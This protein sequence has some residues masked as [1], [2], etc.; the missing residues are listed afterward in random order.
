MDQRATP[1]ALLTAEAVRATGVA[2]LALARRGR[3]KNWTLDESRL[4]ATAE[5]VAEVTRENYPDLRVPYHSRWRHFEIGHDRFKTAYAAFGLSGAER[6]R[7]RIELAIVSV[8]LDAGAGD[9][10][11]YATEEGTFGR[12]E[13]LAL[14]SLDLV[15]RGHFAR[16]GSA[17]WCVDAEKLE[18][19]TPTH[20]ARAF[21]VTADNPLAGLDGRAG[22]L[23]ALGARVAHRS[24]IFGQPARLGRFYDHLARRAKN[25]RIK[26]AKILES[27][28]GVF[29]P[30]W[31]GRVVLDDVPLGDV[32]PHPQLGHACFHKLSQWLAYS[33][34]EPLQEAGIAV[35]ELDGLTGL[36]EYRNGGLFVD[37]GVITPRD[38]GVTQSA[39]P[40]ASPLIVEWRALTV[41]LLDELAQRVR[42]VFKLEAE[43]Q[44]RPPPDLPLASILQ[45]GTWAAGR[46]LASRRVGGGPPITVASDGTVF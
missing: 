18:G 2:A 4:G 43:A 25:G 33:L 46:R 22:L 34:V 28:L 30:I 36:A 24:D 44:H 3:L 10:W 6:A 8:L 15:A 27:I 41:G 32:W 9:R 17:A 40:V 35:A 26:A 11:R 29:N 37:M 1:E 39:Q 42:T 21:Q 14:A 12:S 19:F 23:A 5:Y 45:G 38:A 13:G 7:A 31:P 20:L 16:D